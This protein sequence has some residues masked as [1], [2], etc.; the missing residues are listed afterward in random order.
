M[1]DSIE[2]P[3]GIVFI[4]NFGFAE[5][6]WKTGFRDERQGQYSRAQKWLDD[7]VLD[8]CEPY[9][10]MRTGMLIKSGILGSYV[11]SGTVS[12]IAPYA[13]RQYYSP[14]SAGSIF[15]ALRGSRWFE[16]AKAVNKERWIAGARR[17]AG[18]GR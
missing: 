10:P 8:D 12:W 16:R 1:V 6:V 3:R 14:R 15:G 13:R 17:I 11:G 2:T 4:N 9:V 18:G 7:T 5:L